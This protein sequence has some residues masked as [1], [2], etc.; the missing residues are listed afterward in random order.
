[1]EESIIKLNLIENNIFKKL[2]E[3][4]LEKV[5][6]YRD[7]LVNEITKIIKKSKDYEKKYG[8]KFLIFIPY[9]LSLLEN[10]KIEIKLNFSKQQ[11]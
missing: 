3:N 4:D 10:Y 8:E 9:I 11:R 1:M 6:E 5:N 7:E 2:S